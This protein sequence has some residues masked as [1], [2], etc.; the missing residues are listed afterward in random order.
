LRLNIGV[1]A[2]VSPEVTQSNFHSISSLPEKFVTTQA[3][4]L[5]KDGGHP[6]N[7]LAGSVVIKSF[8]LLLIDSCEAQR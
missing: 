3:A 8:S 5:L 4:L 2:F 6:P 7:S 1:L